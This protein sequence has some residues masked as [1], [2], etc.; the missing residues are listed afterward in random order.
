M[1]TL[2][3]RGKVSDDAKLVLDLPNAFKGATVEVEYSV[4]RVPDKFA[5]KK[6]LERFVDSV[7]GS[8]TDPTFERPPQGEMPPAPSF[9]Q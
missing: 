6:E 4:K 5:D 2:T 7:Y 8:I 1:E 9:D 3:A